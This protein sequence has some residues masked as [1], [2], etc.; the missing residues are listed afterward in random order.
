MYEN[1][2]SI[3]MASLGRTSEKVVQVNKFTSLVLEITSLFNASFLIA[4]VKSWKSIQVNK[5]LF[6]IL[7]FGYFC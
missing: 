6:I 1:Q 5:S 7:L 2:N 4:Q 3:S